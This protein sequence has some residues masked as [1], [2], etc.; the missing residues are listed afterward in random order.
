MYKILKEEFPQLKVYPGVANFL[1]AQTDDHDDKI[2]KAL[3]DKG[4]LIRTYKDPLNGDTYS[5]RITIGKKEEMDIF[6]KA[7]KEILG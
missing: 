7:L 3:A 4:I 2:R 1:Y 6:L 5:L